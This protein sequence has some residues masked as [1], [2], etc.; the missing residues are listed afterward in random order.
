MVLSRDM[1]AF[2][3]AGEPEKVRQAYGDSEFAAGCLLARRLV[4]S[5][6]TFV[7]VASP[8][9]DTH[10]DNFKRTPSLR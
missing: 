8:G 4:E 9:W 10:A 5:G 1:D 3:L 2:D 6:V 7:E